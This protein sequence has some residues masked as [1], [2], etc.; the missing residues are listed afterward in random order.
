[1]GGSEI[2]NSSDQIENEIKGLKNMLFSQYGK[3]DYSLRYEFFKEKFPEI[4]KQIIEPALKDSNVQP[5]KFMIGHNTPT[6]YNKSTKTLVINS[7]D[8][9]EVYSNSLSPEK[10]SEKITT[11]VN[12]NQSKG[13]S[14]FDA[15]RNSSVISDA[16]HINDGS[17]LPSP[18]NHQNLANLQPQKN[19]RG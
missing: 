8:F 5:E 12:N 7:K 16:T 3:N 9:D 15:I 18:T 2:L 14:M 13:G 4:T 11:E 17:T 6:S 10:L 19:G 1:M